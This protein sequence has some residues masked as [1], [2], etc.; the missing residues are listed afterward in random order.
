MLIQRI[1]TNIFARILTEMDVKGFP[2]DYWGKFSEGGDGPEWLPLLDHMTDV[3]ACFE[4][5]VEAGHREALAAAAGL[6][7]LSRTQVSRLIVLAFLHDLGKGNAGF[8]SKIFSETMGMPKPAGHVFEALPLIF[9]PPGLK[10]IS[11]FES[12]TRWFSSGNEDG[13]IALMRMLICSYSHH[14]KPVSFSFQNR[15]ASKRDLDAVKWSGWKYL[16]LDRLLRSAR[17]TAERNWHDAFHQCDDPIPL[18]PA[19]MEAFNGLLTLADW[20]GS[21]SRHFAFDTPDGFGDRADFSAVTAE[22]LLRGIGIV[23]SEDDFE[24]VEFLDVFGFQP[25]AMQQAMV[26]SS[27]AVLQ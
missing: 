24:D 17:Q 5:L 9:S 1:R 14:G 20:M 4:K 18:T 19:F 12:S 22:R 21:D 11:M 13:V 16:D 25:N 2:T 6:H 10:F 27:T 8:Q 7:E 3:A 26:T 15:A 23:H